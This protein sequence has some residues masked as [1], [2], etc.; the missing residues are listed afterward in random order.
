MIDWSM[1]VNWIITGLLGV[2]FGTS[3][4][5]VAYRYN[6][7]RDDIKWERDRT[8]REEDWQREQEKLRQQWTHEQ[9]LRE[10]QWKQEKQKQQ[11]QWEHDRELLKAQFQ[12]R[13]AVR[14]SRFF[15][16][17]RACFKVEFSFPN[18]LTIAVLL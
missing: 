9:Q 17:K 10:E 4:A 2:V 8:R 13:L 1:L 14:W 12:Q 11:E 3:S 5:W 16:K 7:K 18:L 15:D 6:R